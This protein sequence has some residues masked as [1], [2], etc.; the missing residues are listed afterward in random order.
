M[1]ALSEHLCS[2]AGNWGP[3]GTSARLRFQQAICSPVWGS[4]PC[5]G[6]DIRAP[7]VA[8]SF[9][10]RETERAVMWSWESPFGKGRG[11]WGWAGCLT[12]EN[13]AQAPVWSS[14]NFL[15]RD[16]AIKSFSCLLRATGFSRGGVGVSSELPRGREEWFR[17]AL[18]A[19]LLLTAP[20]R[21]SLC[22]ARQ[23]LD[24]WRFERGEPEGGGRWA[25]GVSLREGGRR[26]GEVAEEGVWL[27]R[28]A[29]L[30]GLEG[31]S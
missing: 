18:L 29:L 21:Q 19:T 31:L 26:H 10:W 7:F 20:S 13:K 4:L 3:P 12:V 23:V 25:S 24:V 6:A 27:A 14:A 2:V 11:L 8:K 30:A 5:K 9:L 22:G 17:P 1:V 28:A 15:K 16:F